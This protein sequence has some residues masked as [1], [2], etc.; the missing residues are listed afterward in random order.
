MNDSIQQATYNWQGEKILIADDD[1]F[2]YLLLARVLKK[3]G[4]ELF[5]ASDGEEALN[6]L[7]NDK[8]IK[9]A[10]LDILMPKLNGTEVVK[11]MKEI[12]P[13]LIFIA[14]TA[15]VVRFDSIK[16]K[17]FGFNACI[18]K[19]ILPARFLRILNESFELRGQ[20]QEE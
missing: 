7:M 4:A 14:Y 1:S 10:I 5:F 18:S 8:S 17:D 6:V 11:S 19:P 12:R 13:D 9:V 16:C 15:D 2:S 20:L 3:T